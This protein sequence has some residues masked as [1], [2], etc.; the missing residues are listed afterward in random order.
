MTDSC[1]PIQRKEEEETPHLAVILYNLVLCNPD[2]CH[3]FRP[4]EANSLQTSA[5]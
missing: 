4:R 1:P 3:K 2:K 5:P